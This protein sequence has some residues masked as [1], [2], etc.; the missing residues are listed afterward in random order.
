MHIGEPQP[1][2][3]EELDPDAPGWL[4]SKAWQRA[5]RVVWGAH[6]GA[7]TTTL[8]TW[9]QP[10]WDMGAAR[11]PMHPR[12]PATVAAARPLIIACRSTAWSARAATNA[13]AAV[14][15]AGSR[16]AVLAIISDGWPE[17][18]A[19]TARFRLLEP[20]T[21]AIVRVPFV[22]GLRLADDPATIALP[23]RAL[24][25]LDQIRAATG[26]PQQIR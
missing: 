22:P 23:R 8:A 6:G 3:P 5:E 11:P 2:P 13:V 21:A 16:A 15:Q 12:Y 14:T 10:A 26:G 4:L 9:L 24:R 7:G 17:P 25:A 1:P 20:Q 18:P 19:A